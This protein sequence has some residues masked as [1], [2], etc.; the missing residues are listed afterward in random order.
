[1]ITFDDSIELP[2]LRLELAK[3]DRTV[4]G[5]L[6]NISNR[7][8]SLKLRE[9][10]E[11]SFTLPYY[12]EKN[13]VSVLNPI[14]EKLRSQYLVKRTFKNQVEWYILSSTSSADDNKVKTCNVTVSSLGYQ[15]SNKKIRTWAG[16]LVDG[17]Y[18][19]E[20]LNPQQVLSALLKNSNWSIDYIDADFLLMY[21]SFDFNNTN[22]LDAVFEVAQRFNGIIKWD[23]VNK[24]I[25][26]IKEENAGTNK[27]FRVTINKYLKSIRKDEKLNEVITRLKVYG[28]DGISIQ[29][30]NPLGTDY[31]EDYSY[32]MSGFK[33]DSNKNVISSATHMS[34]SLCNAL[35]DYNELVATKKG[36]FSELLTQKETKEK[37][38]VPILNKINEIKVELAKVNDLIE[39]N[40][41]NNTDT[42]ELFTKKANF[43]EQIHNKE[44]EFAEIDTQILAIETQINELQS[45]IKISNVLTPENLVEL[46]DYI[47]E[48]IWEDSNYTDPKVMMEDAQKV[49]DDSKKPKQEI[50]MDIINFYN[51]IEGKKDWDRLDLGDKFKAFYEDFNIDIETQLIE[52]NLDHDGNSI[53]ITFS[54]TKSN[55]NDEDKFVEQIKNAISTSN[56]VN[57]G[58]YSWDNIHKVETEVNTYIN[59]RLD[60]A[61][62]EIVGGLNENVIINERGI[63]SLDTDDPLKFIRIMHSVIGLTNDGGNT[64]KTAISPEGVV[65]EQLAGKILIG[66]NLYMEN[67]S[68]KF[69]FDHNGVVLDG[70]SLTITNG[71]PPSQLDPTFKDSLV[72]LNKDYTNGIRM[73]SLNGIVVTRN[74]DKVKAYFN[75]TDGIKFQIKKGNTWEDGLYY[76]VA[77]SSLVVNG[78]VYAKDLKIGGRS[79]LTEDDKFSTSYIEKLEVGKNVIMGANASIKWS[80]ITGRPSV[81][82]K[83]SD[84]GALPSTYID[85][86]GVFTAN[87]YAEN[88][89]GKKISTVDFESYGKYNTKVLISEGKIVSTGE[90][91]NTSYVSGGVLGTTIKY[92]GAG[93]Q[94]FMIKPDSEA[95]MSLSCTNS[96]GYA[97][98]LRMYANF[99]F[100]GSIDF[101]SATINWGKNTPTAKFG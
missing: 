55:V 46:D 89:M 100:A 53:S 2:K 34:D 75:A 54:N 52:M 32:F 88:I 69:R 49:F 67:E 85:S 83:P 28:Q 8:Q 41:K 76:D 21:R 3:P 29:T 61:K 94:D 84:I 16:V 78:I 39:I 58:K 60:A 51:C 27:G 93:Y 47:I 33:R 18:R 66:G 13:N 9:L 23:T 45:A 98:E 63:T 24:R 57:T 77:D 26:L 90:N 74:D 6:K 101:T 20:S 72:E 92:G 86:S 19:K 80:Q 44:V 42:T 62:Q 59:N 7:N 12:I 25:S 30:V 70:S 71:L 15:L 31:L 36:Q 68:G 37:E 48:D 22:V 64:F 79:V 56:T 81:P 5:I 1:M 91:S 65:A 14:I 17:K 82:T 95:I 43:E 73:D 4:V 50:T 40:Q 99:S 10:N 96:N 35:L 97:S 11:I 38:Q 87:V